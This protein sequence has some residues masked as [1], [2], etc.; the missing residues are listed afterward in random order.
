MR[1][2]RRS[3]AAASPDAR[4][5]YIKEVADRSVARKV[6]G[7]G[8]LELDKIDVRREIGGGDGAPLLLDPELFTIPCSPARLVLHTAEEGRDWM[9][10][11][12]AEK[13]PPFPHVHQGSRVA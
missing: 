6:G 1:D 2:Q 4:Q 12:L 8:R 7:S 9:Q 3:G 13:P 10:V 11:Q 5:R